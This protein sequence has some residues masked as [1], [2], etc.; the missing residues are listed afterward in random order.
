MQPRWTN[1]EPGKIVVIESAQTVAPGSG[2]G[3]SELT[4]DFEAAL[5]SRIPFVVRGAAAQ[6]PAREWTAQQLEAAFGANGASQYWHHLPAGRFDR[7]DT[8]CPGWLTEHWQRRAQRLSLER[9]LRFWQ[10]A[11]GHQTPWHY[12]GNALDVLNVQLAG[13]KHFTLAAPHR[14][15][16]WIRFLPV[17]TLAYADPELPVQHVILDAGDLIFI[18]RFWSHRVEAL[19]TDN[20]NLNWVWTDADFAADSAVAS[21]EAERLA[22]V[23]KL[24]SAGTLERLVSGYEATSLRRELQSYGGRQHVSLVSRMLDTVTPER[25]DARIAIELENESGDA[26]IA[27]LEPRARRLFVAE[28][29]GAAPPG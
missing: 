14:E 6:W 29:F 4:H 10:A 25:T 5:A 15:L 18:P 28:M 12:D 13:R 27:R 24:A 26:F 7:A 11:Q 2:I 20:R 16:P 19:D 17:S 8:P 9:P 3:V 22:A 21:R 23:K 1:H